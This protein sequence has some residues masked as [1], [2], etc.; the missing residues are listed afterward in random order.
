[1]DSKLDS[2]AIQTTASNTKVYRFKLL[3]EALPGL[4]MIGISAITIPAWIQSA[5]DE[6]LGVPVLVAIG[7]IAFALT[8]MLDVFSPTVEMVTG[9]V[10]DLRSRKAT[11][12]PGV[13]R[14]RV[15]HSV[16]IGSIRLY[17]TDSDLVMNVAVGQRC[18]VIYGRNTKLILAL[19]VQDEKEA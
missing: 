6:P 5:N 9:K 13:W 3:K 18:T 4:I 14:L 17:T 1:M 11:P 2:S 16:T 10:V 8:K 19:H 12:A 7:G 15:F